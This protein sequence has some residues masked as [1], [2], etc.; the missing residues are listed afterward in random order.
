MQ[1]ISNQLECARI[2]IRNLVATEQATP[3]E[4]A[5]YTVRSLNLPQYT[6]VSLLEY[7]KNLV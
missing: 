3:E 6:K 7:A 1:D 4:A 5:A 2:V